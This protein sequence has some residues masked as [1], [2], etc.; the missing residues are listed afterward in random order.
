MSTS[1][2]TLCTLGT[3]LLAA[4]VQGSSAS[5]KDEREPLSEEIVVQGTR[6][7][8]RYLLGWHE[9]VSQHFVLDSDLPTGTAAELIRRLE[10]LRAS[11]LRSVNVDDTLAPGRV[12]VIAS[13]ASLLFTELAQ[14]RFFIGSFL[15]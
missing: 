6:T 9:Y 1:P 10:K 8:E 12:R 7:P 5:A 11:E 4:M 13:S 2:R 14:D 15:R 3:I